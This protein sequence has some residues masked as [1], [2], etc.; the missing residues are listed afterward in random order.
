MRAGIVS[1]IE[2]VKIGRRPAV[3][4]A[5][6]SLAT[7]LL[8]MY[9][10]MSYQHLDKPESPAFS[11]PDAW[12]YA[13]EGPGKL[14]AFFAAMVLMLLVTGEFTWKTARQNVID[15]LS[16][17]EFF[18][19]KVLTIPVV[20]LLFLAVPLLMAGAIGALQTS[21]GELLMRR[22]D[23]LLVAGGLLRNLGYASLA[24]LIALGARSSGGAAGLFFLWAIA[25]NIVA[26]P[27]SQL[28]PAL[29]NVQQF[30]PLATFDALG[31]PVRYG[32]VRPRP[33][34]V[35]QALTSNGTMAAVASAWIVAFIVASYV[36]VHERDL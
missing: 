36:V 27:L 13:I 17:E 1:H 16:K 24:L 29:R 33:G 12:S 6:A 9:G 21:P 8:L 35:V 18:A 14:A 26:G 22:G 4:V 11:L 2:A 30:M 28:N 23:A 20:A 31:A 10:S 32:L 19:A 7:L 25:E 15:G 34:E 5:G 3:W